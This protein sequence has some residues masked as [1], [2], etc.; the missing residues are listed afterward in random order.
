MDTWQ[1]KFS[2]P[3]QP[4]GQFV[5]KVVLVRDGVEIVTEAMLNVDKHKYLADH[6]WKVFN[7][8]P[9]CYLI[10]LRLLRERSSYQLLWES[11]L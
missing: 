6:I 5:D 11:R 10:L 9:Y 3:P 8:L 4:Q 7:H 2:A 1:P